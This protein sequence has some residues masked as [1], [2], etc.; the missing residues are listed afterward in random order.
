MLRGIKKLVAVSAV[1]AVIGTGIH[2]VAHDFQTHS[3][4]SCALCIA[5]SSVIPVNSVTAQPADPTI[6]FTVALVADVSVKSTF[7]NTVLS[8]GP[9]VL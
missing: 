1:F 2:A 5:A 6:S 3:K 4:D 7:Y 8:R 9:P